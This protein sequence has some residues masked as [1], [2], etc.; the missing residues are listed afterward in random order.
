MTPRALMIS[1]LAAAGLLTAHAHAQHAMP[2]V[3]IRSD[4]LPG[5]GHS[6]GFA[7]L[8]PTR[9]YLFIARRENG[10]SVFDTAARRLVKNVPGTESANAVAF[11]PALDRAYVATMDGT[12]VELR[13]SDMTPLRRIQVDDG[14]LNNLV[15]DGISGKLV[16]TG[17]RRTQQSTIWLFDPHAGRIV[18][19]R[20]FDARKFDAPLGLADGSVVVPLRD[21]GRVMRISA[22]SLEPLPGWSGKQFPGCEHPSALAADEQRSRLFIACRGKTPQLTIAELSDGKPLATLPAT[23]A[24]NAMAWD[25]VRRLLLV[26]SGQA[27]NL[28]LI[29]EQG[30]GYRTLGYAGT[31]PWAHNMTYDARRGVAYV[32]TMD[33][34]QPAPADNGDKNGHKPDPVF[35][36]DSFTI[37]G[38]ELSAAQTQTQASASSR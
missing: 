27:A 37:L 1:V 21:E 14:N 24:I 13:L 15:F 22:A 12:L 20:R 10:L 11:A 4:V 18:K 28:T 31:R 2:A 29:G 16:I 35:H 8:D 25:G 19:Q 6:W 7:A 32:F 33:F 9:P 3:S 17:G 36:A 34:T 38:V 23:P 5:S 30:D 26:P